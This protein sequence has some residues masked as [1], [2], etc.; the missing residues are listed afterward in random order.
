MLLNEGTVNWWEEWTGKHPHRDDLPVSTVAVAFDR[1]HPD[2]VV[3]LDVGQWTGED[4]AR[5]GGWLADELAGDITE[6]A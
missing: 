2:D 5:L 4:V 3:V 6:L 1:L